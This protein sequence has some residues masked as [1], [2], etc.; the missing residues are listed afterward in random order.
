MRLR[1]F[2]CDSA[3][4]GVRRSNADSSFCS[5][6]YIVVSKWLRPAV[7]PL[8]YARTAKTA[9]D[10]GLDTEFYSKLH[11]AGVARRERTGRTTLPLPEIPSGR[12]P[13]YNYIRLENWPR[14]VKQKL[15][16]YALDKAIV[17]IECLRQ[18]SPA[19]GRWIAL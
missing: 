14:A 6:G 19:S 1:F 2:L 4:F 11:P 18:S 10:F 16:N 17:A 7:R 3:D 13:C 12:K 5:S 9:R 15:R 8:D